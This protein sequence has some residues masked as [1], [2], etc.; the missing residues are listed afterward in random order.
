MK[1]RLCPLLKAF[2]KFE[3]NSPRIAAFS[4]MKRMQDVRFCSLSIQRRGVIEFSLPK[5]VRKAKGRRIFCAAP[6]LSR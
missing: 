1:G 6:G 2:T 5:I 3:T 4:P